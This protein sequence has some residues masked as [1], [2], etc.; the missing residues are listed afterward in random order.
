[1]S[2][3]LDGQ[4]PPN[5]AS[6]A[7]APPDA[8]SDAPPPPP[9]EA[10][11]C[12]DASD[13]CQSPEVPTGWSPVAYVEN[14]QSACP[15][16]WS[17]ADDYVTGATQGTATCNC[18]CTVTTAPSCTTGTLPTYYS[19][20]P[21]CGSQG[22]SL[23]FNQGGCVTVGGNLSNYYS[24]PALAPSGGVCNVQASSSGSL[25]STPVRLCI[26]ATECTWAACDGVAPPGYAACIVA[27]G[28]QPCPSGSSF[29]VKHG[30]A[31]SVAA[32]CSTC[33]T[34]C[35]FQGT[36]DNPKLNTFGGVGCTNPGASL[37]SDGTCV[38]T[39]G[40]GYVASATYSAT[41]NFT[42]C[43][44]AGTSSVQ[45]VPTTPKTVCC[46]P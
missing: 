34:S 21:G 1:V 29:S 24:S 18:D 22:V 35:T 42:G 36:C 26:P 17:T 40:G 6:T 10:G 31:Q 28:D 19:S 33:G 11:L 12:D 46:R 4:P 30:I 2:P 37:A 8:P 45:I 41:A 3:P 20:G 25:Q 23:T 14:P 39:G 38:S 7:D 27:D 5:E 43:T 13:G 15:A 16:S 9:I 44:A 32:S